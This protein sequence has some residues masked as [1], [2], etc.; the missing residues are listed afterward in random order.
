MN[1]QTSNGSVLLARQGLQSYSQFHSE[2]QPHFLFD[3]KT[4][5][6]VCVEPDLVNFISAGYALPPLTSPCARFC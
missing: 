3:G 4:T 2:R 6:S 5:D 1:A